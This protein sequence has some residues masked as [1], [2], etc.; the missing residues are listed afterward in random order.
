MVF[1]IPRVITLG[2]NFFNYSA[3]SAQVGLSP[4]T[5]TVVGLCIRTRNAGGQTEELPGELGNQQMPAPQRRE[6][7]GGG[8]AAKERKSLD[9]R[10]VGTIKPCPPYLTRATLDLW[11]CFGDFLYLMGKRLRFSMP[12][13]DLGIEFKLVLQVA[14]HE[15]VDDLAR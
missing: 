6:K 14:F 7:I 10:T 5:F 4:L 8:M 12:H 3:T 15:F 1:D 9:G 13:G 11:H 2:S